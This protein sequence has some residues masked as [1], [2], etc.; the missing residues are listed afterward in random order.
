MKPSLQLHPCSAVAD[1]HGAEEEGKGGGHRKEG[2]IFISL[3]SCDVETDRNETGEHHG[4]LPHNVAL[5][6]PS[7]IDHQT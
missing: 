1:D 2:Q 7:V 5:P 4:N 6:V 3:E